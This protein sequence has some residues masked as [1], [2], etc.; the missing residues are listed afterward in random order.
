[1]SGLGTV[2]NASIP[3]GLLSAA[4][5]SSHISGRLFFFFFTNSAFHFAVLIASSSPFVIL[6]NRIA[7]KAPVG[8][9]VGGFDIARLFRDDVG[10]QHVFVSVDV[11]VVLYFLWRL[12]VPWKPNL[13]LYLASSVP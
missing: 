12:S 13:L 1:M 7:S 4:R 5:S 2:S 11:V 9:E 10:T 8:T 3:S 6:R